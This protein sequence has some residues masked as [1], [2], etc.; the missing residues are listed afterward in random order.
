MATQINESS[1]INNYDSTYSSDSADSDEETMKLSSCGTY[2]AMWNH[3]YGRSFGAKVPDVSNILTVT[4]TRDNSVLCK[5]PLN[6]YQ[7][8]TPCVEFFKHPE[9]DETVFTCNMFHGE[10]TLLNLKGSW[11]AQLW[12][13]AIQMDI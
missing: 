5:V 13:I 2:K 3:G 8:Q 9:T 10:L 7:I 12:G 6:R 11:G 4:D 1:Q